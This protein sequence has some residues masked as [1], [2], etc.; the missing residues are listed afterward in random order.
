MKNYIRILIFSLMILSC[1]RDKTN[2]YSADYYYVQGL[3][4]YQNE[5]YKEALINIDKAIALD[6]AVSDYY[7]NRGVIKELVYNDLSSALI[8]YE[9]AIEL[10]DKNAVAYYN[11][12]CILSDVGN[13][14]AALEFF[15]KAIEI[16]PNYYPAYFNYACSQFKVK[17]YDEALKNFK[18]AADYDENAK[19]NALYYIGL[20]YK[21]KGEPENA[22]KYF[23]EVAEAGYEDAKKELL[24]K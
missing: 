2:T 16:Y 19:I 4:L 10:D 12:G 6:S 13:D 23:E 22:K 1:N 20:V 21:E 17:N 8:D 24:P 5:N 18:I 11:I 14:Q 3:S 7:L 9:K 15:E